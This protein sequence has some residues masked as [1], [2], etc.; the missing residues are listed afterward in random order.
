VLYAPAIATVLLVAIL[1]VGEATGSWPLRAISKPLASLGFILFALTSGALSAGNAGI[2]IVVALVLS[3]IGDVLLLWTARGPFL[4]GLIAFL[5][6]HLGFGVAFLVM[7]VSPA[8]VG[9]SAVVLLPIAG[10][11]WVLFGRRAGK[12]AGPVMAYIAVISVMVALAGGAA[13]LDPTPTRITLLVAAVVFFA[14]D[15]C[16]AR[17]R[18]VSKGFENRVVGLPLY[19]GAQLLFAGAGGAIT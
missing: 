7:G 15:L 19:Y 10:L 1:L 2:A 12:L 13:W 9:I 14:S 4:A 18:F 16:V 11:A 8:G 5:L 17:D 6:G 3:A